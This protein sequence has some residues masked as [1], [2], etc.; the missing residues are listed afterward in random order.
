MSKSTEYFEVWAKPDK[1]DLDLKVRRDIINPLMNKIQAGTGMTVD[2]R[3]E[4]GGKSAWILE[5]SDGDGAASLILTYVIN[6]I[7]TTET[8][9]V[10]ESKWNWYFLS[11][12]TASFSF[13]RPALQVVTGNVSISMH[14]VWEQSNDWNLTLGSAIRGQANYAID[15]LHTKI[16]NLNDHIKVVHNKARL[17][18]NQY[19]KAMLK[20]WVVQD[21]K[22]MQTLQTSAKV[23]EALS[24]M[25]TANA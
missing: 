20:G 14:E 10:D 4:A 3:F 9:W 2:L 22:I 13:P 23:L 7:F 8:D 19:K 1:D 5:M 15:A 24:E 6:P 11:N 25:F 16:E 12:I 21:A 17:P 18:E